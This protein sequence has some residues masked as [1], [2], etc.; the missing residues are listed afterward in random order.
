[1]YF[2]FVVYS[3]HCSCEKINSVHLNH[4]LD[5][6]LSQPQQSDVMWTMGFSESLNL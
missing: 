3:Q 2:I 5:S 4:L 1:M 6:E